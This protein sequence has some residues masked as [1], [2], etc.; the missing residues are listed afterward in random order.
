MTDK[1]AI[2][3]VDDDP[4]I[5]R[6]TGLRLRAAGYRTHMASDGDEG[7]AAAAAEH[8]DLI[9]LDVR[10]PRKDGLTALADL[11]RRSD[12]QAIPVVILSASIVDEKAALD[13]GARFFI[14]KP[15]RGDLLLKA[16]RTAMSP[17]D[18]AACASEHE[19]HVRSTDPDQLPI[20]PPVE[21]HFT[22]A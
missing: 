4:E 19:R 22:K 17:E 13:A 14:R 20:P 11:K 9:L 10:M 5:L 12:T 16:I 6:A 8:P 2:L 1:G 7:I 3:M 21:R 18:H 15:Y